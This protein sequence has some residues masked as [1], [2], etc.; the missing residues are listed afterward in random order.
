[1]INCTRPL[2]AASYSAQSVL[3]AVWLASALHT[4]EFVASR[5]M[6]LSY[7]NK[8]WGYNKLGA[9]L[10]G[11]A[12]FQGNNTPEIVCSVYGIVFDFYEGG[13]E[14]FRYG[15]YVG[16]RWLVIKGN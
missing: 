2:L 16:V 13:G 14:C 1:M 11:V 15:G 3:L 4:L 9:V 8:S 6:L 10:F 7:K 5:A 12:G